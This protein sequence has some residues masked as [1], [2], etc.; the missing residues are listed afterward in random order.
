MSDFVLAGIENLEKVLEGI[1]S[2]LH[3]I[4]EIEGMTKQEVK[5]RLEMPY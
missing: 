1:S 2:S 3:Y 4:I 5:Q